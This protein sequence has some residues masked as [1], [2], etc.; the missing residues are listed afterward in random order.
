MR[1][2]KC[3]RRFRETGSFA[4]L[5]LSLAM[6]A[7]LVPARA[8]AAPAEQTA[9]QVSHFSAYVGSA[10]HYSILCEAESTVSD[11]AVGEGTLLPDGG[12]VGFVY[13][14]ERSSLQGQALQVGPHEVV[15][16]TR[17]EDAGHRV[18]SFTLKVAGSNSGPSGVNRIL[19]AIAVWGGRAS[20]TARVDGE[21]VPVLADDGGAVYVSPEAFTGGVFY[22]DG[23]R[24]VALLRAYAH[25]S[26]GGP[27]FVG[28]SLGDQAGRG[29]IATDD[30]DPLKPADY[31]QSGFC[32]TARPAVGNVAVEVAV[33]ATYDGAA[34]S[35]AWI[36]DLPPGT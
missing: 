34:T 35:E 11:W 20:C 23:A 33:G 28:V 13:P 5:T 1:A 10:F 17:V 25:A 6:F 30:P 7:V 24:H 2:T 19:V 32:W 16:S 3:I 9:T 36:I 21:D 8:G 15:T 29:F 12:M 18:S 14:N 27:A 4:P 26:L 31:C 22:Q